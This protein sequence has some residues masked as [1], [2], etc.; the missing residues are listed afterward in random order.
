MD[1]G[2]IWGLWLGGQGA[3]EHDGVQQMEGTELA[4]DKP[5]MWEAEGMFQAEETW[6]KDVQEYT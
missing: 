3:K 6:H 2:M 5:V 1:V 4:Q